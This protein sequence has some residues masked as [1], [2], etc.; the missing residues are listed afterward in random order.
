I[1]T[2]PKGLSNIARLSPGHKRNRGTRYAHHQP[3]RAQGVRSTSPCGSRF[4]RYP[5]ATAAPDGGVAHECAR[6]SF[7]VSRSAQP[8]HMDSRSIMAEIASDE[9]RR[10]ISECYAQAVKR[11][12]RTHPLGVTEKELRII[13]F[14]LREALERERPFN[15]ETASTIGC[16]LHR[17]EPT[18]FDE[19]GKFNKQKEGM[20]EIAMDE[21][22]SIA[23]Q[24]LDEN[25]HYT[26]LQLST[27]RS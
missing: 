7:S 18:V 23:F 19:E 1:H 2:A 16:L 17:L 26:V 22:K 14:A 9:L 27:F 15:A 21:P 3:G 25:A 5:V 11:H 24:E 12:A 4:S 13:L 10:L 6:G 20:Q 8:G